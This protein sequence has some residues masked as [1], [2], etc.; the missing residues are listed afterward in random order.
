MI[1]LFTFESFFKILTIEKVTSW[2]SLW[3]TSQLVKINSCATSNACTMRTEMDARLDVRFD[4]GF[5]AIRAVQ[6]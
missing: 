4:T 3:S 1:K 6:M 2:L 5:K